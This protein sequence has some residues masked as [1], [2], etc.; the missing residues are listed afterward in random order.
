MSLS[1]LHLRAGTLAGQIKQA[2][3]DV[4]ESVIQLDR[5]KKA[6]EREERALEKH[7]AS[8]AQLRL[9]RSALQAEA[10]ALIGRIGEPMPVAAGEEVST[11]AG[12]GDQAV[13]APCAT[14]LR[15][16]GS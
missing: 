1:D 4:A 6:V 14:T 3:A 16:I 12:E 11:S 5:A 13:P 10:I 9:A 15:V 2:D 7:T 8:A